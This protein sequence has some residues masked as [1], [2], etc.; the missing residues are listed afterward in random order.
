M[1]K[2]YMV[3]NSKPFSAAQKEV[4]AVLDKQIVK[5]FEAIKQAEEI[6]QPQV[7]RLHSLLLKC[8][9]IKSIN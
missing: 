5:A 7:E 3:S 6:C 4:I 8:K 2:D 1:K 9:K